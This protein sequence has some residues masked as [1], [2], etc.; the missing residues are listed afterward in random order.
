MRGLTFRE[1]NAG[2]RIDEHM[3]DA[4]FNNQIGVDPATGF[5]YG[6][7]VENCG[8]WMDKMGSS[9]AAGNK[10]GPSTP[11]DGSAVEIVGL[12]YSC[13]T[14]LA[15]IPQYKHQ[16]NIQRYILYTVNILI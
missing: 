2:S 10:G 13:L 4:G 14:A 15:T 11:R 16:V 12:A 8:T 3:R 6:G 7:N 1:W 5:V 9:G